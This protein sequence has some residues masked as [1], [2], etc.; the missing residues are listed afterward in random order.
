MSVT[1]ISD[2]DI[3]AD[4]K[5]NRFIVTPGIEDYG[6]RHLI[7]LT[8]IGYWYHNADALAQWCAD[9]NARTQGMTVEIDSDE[10]LVMFTLRWS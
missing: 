8:D 7:V 1:L 6:C 10:A 9:H 3:L 4:W 2:D 5:K